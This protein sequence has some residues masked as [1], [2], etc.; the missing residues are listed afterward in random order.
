MWY[1][2]GWEWGKLSKPWQPRKKQQGN[3]NENISN[4][5]FQTLSNDQITELED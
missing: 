1:G 3:D 2:T 5:I 4:K